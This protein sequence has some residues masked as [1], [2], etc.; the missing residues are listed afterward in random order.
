[1][2]R[3]PLRPRAAAAP[4]AGAS[5][6]VTSALVGFVALF[7][8]LAP[9]GAAPGRARVCSAAG[10]RL[11]ERPYEAPTSDWG[12]QQALPCPA[13]LLP[14]ERA[15][16]GSPAAGLK[17][18]GPALALAPAG[19]EH[20]GAAALVRARLRVRG[21]RQPRSPVLSARAPPPVVLAC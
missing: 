13:H 14:A 4:F 21:P 7:A 6:L 15:E 17:G 2:Q 8:C 9:R 20:P 18:S 11:L 1:M 5:L 3:P 16:G 12:L 10:Q 19:V